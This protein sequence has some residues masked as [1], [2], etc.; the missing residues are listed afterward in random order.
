[1]KINKTWNKLNDK[2]FANLN[3]KWSSLWW[4]DGPI[5]HLFKKI[6]IKTQDTNVLNTRRN[7]VVDAI[8]NFN[9]TATPSSWN[10]ND[11]SV[12]N[13]EVQDRKNTFV[14][15]CK[16]YDA[17]KCYTTVAYTSPMGSSPFQQNLP[18]WLTNLRLREHPGA[19]RFS[20]E[21]HSILET[22]VARGAWLQ[23]SKK[24]THH[25]LM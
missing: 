15:L 6:F 21:G 12:A 22:T 2:R 7:E 19:F 11:E 3:I 13:A 4:G 9:A 16:I 20:Y 10:V 5:E 14:C 23:K 17:R 18:F 24:T 8:A 25:L 1:M